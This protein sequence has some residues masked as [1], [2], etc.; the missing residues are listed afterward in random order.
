MK[1]GNVNIDNRVI[2]APMAGITDMAFR[3]ICKNNGAGLVYSE[4]ISCKGM[5]Y[6]D[7]K[8]YKLIQ[9]NSE[10]RPISVQIFGSDVEVMTTVVEEKLNIRDDI[11]II[12]INMGCPTP[13]IVKN[14]DGSALLKD[15]NKIEQIVKSIVK[16]SVKPVTVK[17]RIGWDKESINAIEVAKAIESSGASAI[18]IHGRTRQQ[19]YSGKA[20]WDIIKKV[21]KSVN[22]P[23]IG[24]GDIYTPEDGKRMFEY[25]NCDAIMIARGSRGNPWIFNRTVA[26]IDEGKILPEPTSLEKIQMCIA[27]LE[28][29]CVIKKPEIAVK[30]MRKHIGWYIKGLKS[31]AKLRNKVNTIND[32]NQLIEELN[33]YIEYMSNE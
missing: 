5:Y 22:I 21:K 13:K 29:L 12:D 18:A 33:R 6:G 15:V 1:I 20:D 25:T 24:N 17:I 3:T 4:M 26:Y 7:K 27:H 14:G 23:V 32:K 31:S 16:I 30:E 8:T 19:F 10:E 11:D 2:L 9:I 28:L